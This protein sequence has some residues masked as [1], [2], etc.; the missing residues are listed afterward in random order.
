MKWMIIL[1]I[2]ILL[3]CIQIITSTT[4]VA[5]VVYP[6]ITPDEFSLHITS[7][8]SMLLLLYYPWDS[9]LDDLTPQLQ[10]VQSQYNETC[11]F[12]INMKKYGEFA[13]RTFQID[14]SPTL[15]YVATEPNSSNSRA[16]EYN[17]IM[18]SKYIVSFLKRFEERR[19]I[20]FV[21]GSDE[22]S[23]ERFLE[24]EFSVA[25]FF[26]DTNNDSVE[27]YSKVQQEKEFVTNTNFGHYLLQEQSLPLYQHIQSFIQTIPNVIIEDE[28]SL[29]LLR[30]EEVTS[31]IL[32][33]SKKLNTIQLFNMNITE[34]L[35]E[36][37]KNNTH[38]LLLEVSASNFQELIDRKQSS[39]ILFIDDSMEEQ[40]QLL[41]SE[42]EQLALEYRNESMNF[43]F[44]DGIRFAEF[45]NRI[46]NGPVT[47]PAIVIIEPRNG[48]GYVCVDSIIGGHCLGKDYYSGLVP[49]KGQIWQFVHGRISERNISELSSEELPRYLAKRVIRSQHVDTLPPSKDNQVHLSLQLFNQLFSVKSNG[50]IR[51]AFVYLYAQSCGYCYKMNFL[52]DEIASY[53]KEISPLLF[54]S[55]DVDQNDLPSLITERH[56][57]EAVPTVISLMAR[58]DGTWVYNKAYK[59]SKD[60][61]QL[62]Q[63]IKSVVEET[64]KIQVNEEAEQIIE[65]HTTNE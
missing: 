1:S 55:M 48:A 9:I 7:C 40:N 65:Y 20:N 26:L 54:T 8:N 17:Y 49:A 56:S 29:E 12:S 23:A 30:N 33:Y 32:L 27:A 13:L 41:L 3:C 16:I 34:S 59:D 57:V 47:L 15:L 25:G 62:I 31:C 39:A 22:F 53:F 10:Q 43:L 4:E 11:Y 14:S 45:M 21:I 24:T 2:Y 44:M 5:T 35:V 28:K 36:W 51:Y 46:H 38:S 6:S 64:T 52:Y 37:L 61:N 50:S 19:R 58:P 18:K 60:Y 42:M 63:W